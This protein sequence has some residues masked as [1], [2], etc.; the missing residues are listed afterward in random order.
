MSISLIDIIEIEWHI[1]EPVVIW[2]IKD[3][4]NYSGTV[5]AIEAPEAIKSPTDGILKILVNSSG[6]TYSYYLNGS[7]IDSSG[8]TNRRVFSIRE[9][10]EV[11]SFA[12][13]AMMESA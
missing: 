12:H 6:K 10:N 1:G 2:S 9:L 8:L 4:K 3:Q 13:E 7:A 5:Y 11:K